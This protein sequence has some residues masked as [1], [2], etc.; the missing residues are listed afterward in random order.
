LTCCFSVAACARACP[1]RAQDIAIPVVVVGA[2]TEPL[3]PDGATI[4]TLS[5]GVQESDVEEAARLV[6]TAIA[7]Y[8]ASQSCKR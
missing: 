7:R 2:S 5:C 6:T 8:V 4:T 3:L 1:P